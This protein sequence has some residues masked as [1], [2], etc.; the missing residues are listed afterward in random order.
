MKVWPDGPT[1][2]TFSL[3]ENSKLTEFNKTKDLNHIV[4]SPQDCGLDGGE[5]CAIWLGPEMPGDQ[6][7]D[8]SHRSVTI[9]KY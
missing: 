4:C 7:R 8:D 5:Y 6:R 3:T 1:I 2:S 9:V